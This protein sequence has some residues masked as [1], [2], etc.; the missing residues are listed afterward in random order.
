MR[1]LEIVR[2][3]RKAARVT[4]WNVGLRG[5]IAILALAWLVFAGTAS[6]QRART[7]QEMRALKCHYL[8]SRVARY[9]AAAAERRLPACEAL[10]RNVGR[11]PEPL[12]AR[13]AWERE[14]R[15][16]RAAA[17]D[18]RQKLE[19]ASLSHAQEMREIKRLARK[20]RARPVDSLEATTR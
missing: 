2:T 1:N 9:D 20:H 11:R 5:G 13:L 3:E 8:V 15:D 4:R 12:P 7:A 19:R 18:H 6:A 16:V 17:R 10:D 14:M